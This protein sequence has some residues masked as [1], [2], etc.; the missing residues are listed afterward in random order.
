MLVIFWLITPLQSS[1]LGIDKVSRS[2]SVDIKTR[3]RL[4]PVEEQEAILNP[5]VL[6]HAYA[7][8]WLGQ[9]YPPFM[10]ADYGLLPFYLEEAP[11]RA[12]SS[13]NWTASTTMYTTD[14]EC[15]PAKVT[16]TGPKE[17]SIYIYDNGQGCAFETRI[18]PTS[19]YSMQYIGYHDNAHSSYWLAGPNC[20]DSSRFEHNFLAIWAA[21]SLG[22]SQGSPKVLE[23]E[24]IT[25]IFCEPSYHEQDVQISVDSE[26]RKPINASLEYVSN[27]RELG[28]DKFNITAFEYLLGNGI[29]QDMQ[30]HDSPFS[31]VLDQSAVLYDMNISIPVTNMVGFAMA[32]QEGETSEYRDPEVLREAFARA[33]RYT[34]SVAMSHLLTNHT[35]S[36]D[37][38]ATSTSALIGVVV[39]RPL[40]AAVEVLLLVV[41]TL[42]GIL[43]WFCHTTPCNLR[44]NPASIGRLLQIFSSSPDILELFQAVDH[45]DEKALYES[46]PNY[47]FRLQAVGRDFDPYIQVLQHTSYDDVAVQPDFS[48]NFYQPVKPIALRRE[49]GLLLV[50]VLMGAMAGL[51][52]LRDEE[53]RQNGLFSERTAIE[54]WGII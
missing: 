15:W 46:F 27:G 33:H 53:R 42:A 16:P 38:T 1:I 6:S 17:R 7:V 54:G 22:S 25:A 9:P 32:G 28:S 29:E 40:A 35:S 20:S 43:L 3:S 30:P 51:F 52:V 19:A 47:R 31:I 26:T 12:Q 8:G 34:F 36:S 24:D 23:Q 50:T 48:K 11:D 5:E 39:N 49:I 2:V 13:K 45:T 44:Q 14:L 10:T 37:S 21:A 18:P 4:M 41:A